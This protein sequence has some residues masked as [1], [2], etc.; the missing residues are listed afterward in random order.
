MTQSQ[1]T[2]PQYYSLK[3]VG[4][5]AGLSA[6]TLAP[7]Q[8]PCSGHRYEVGE[9]IVDYLDSFDHVFLITAGEA[10]VTIYSQV[11][12]VVSFGEAPRSAS[13]EARTSG[14]VASM[15]AAA[16][17]ALL[18]IQPKATLAVLTQLVRKTR[19]VTRRVYESST[20]HANNRIQAE[21]LRLATWPPSWQERTNRPSCYPW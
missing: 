9:T 2:R 21:L 15:R 17:R 8:Q 19:S 4:I 16:F 11:G 18:E 10:H 7:V 3:G 6:N 14:L 20:L 1:A 12:K 13:V 5:F